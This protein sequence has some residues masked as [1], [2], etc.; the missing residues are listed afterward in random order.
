MKQ[1]KG[2]LAAALSLVLTLSAAA[3]T[4]DNTKYNDYYSIDTSS[5]TS[6][7]LYGNGMKIDPVVKN[8]GEVVNAKYSVKVTLDG[9]D[10]TEKVYNAE[11]KMFA[12]GE[13]KDAI[14]LYTFTITIVDDKGGEIKDENGKPF[15]A[16]FTV[17]YCTMNF[18]PKAS[19]GKGVTVDNTDP[20]SPVITFDST[21]TG[22]GE[23]DSGQYRATGVTF[24]GDYE[25]TYKVKIDGVGGGSPK[26]LYFGVDRTDEN[27]R[28]DNIALNVEDGTLSSWFFADNGTAGGS[29][30]TSTGWI[31]TNKSVSGYQ[32]LADGQEHEIG[33]TRVIS[34]SESKH[35]HYVVTWDGKYFTSLN[36]KGNYTDVLGG[37]WV[38]SMNVQ[39]S[40][41]I[42]SYRQLQEDKTSP[43]VVLAYEDQ[44]V[45]STIDLMK[46]LV[47]QDEI[48]NAYSAVQWKVTNPAGEDVTP[49]DGK[50]LLPDS[51]VY[52]V[53]VQVADLKG[54]VSEKVSA[55][56]NVYSDFNIVG[57][58]FDSFHQ[59]GKEISLKASF[60]S[61]DAE[62]IDGATLKI[63]KNGVDTNT[64]IKGN[65]KDGFKFTMTDTGVY[66]AKMTATSAGKQIE[67]SVEFT[68]SGADAANIDVSR[69]TREARTNVAH[70]V[71]AD[72]ANAAEIRIFKGD[73]LTGATDVTAEVMETYTTTTLENNVTYTYFKPK[74]AGRYFVKATFGSGKTYAIRAAEINVR[75]DVIWVYDNEKLD[76]GN[77]QLDKIIYGDNTVIFKANG[78]T[79]YETSKLVYDNL[80]FTGDYTIEFKV[81][82]LNF[83]EKNKKI[84]F[85][86][87]TYETAGSPW[88][89]Y[90]VC[91]EGSPEGDFWGYCTNI[92]GFGWVEYQ[93]R[94]VWQAPVTDEFIPDNDPDYTGE[95]YQYAFREG[96]EYAQYCQGT[97]TYKIDVK[98]TGDKYN[99][100]F[101]IDGRPEATHRNLSA[102]NGTLGC[103][104]IWANT[105]S[106]ALTDISVREI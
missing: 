90:D 93:W 97:H 96:K 59:V 98:K 104:V 39:G 21:Y 34:S 73:T 6:E 5:V 58:G 17:D 38:E 24:K 95:G 27:K 56:I 49:G 68:V 33:F 42:K 94:S 85:T 50:L 81:T 1:L 40:V 53:E 36:I 99:V 86:L 65:A 77:G 22:E 8:L 74:M 13:N 70:I 55:N 2:M 102:Q 89:W 11:T 37:V 44:G 10:V 88:G 80:N 14:G 60:T 52:K 63:Y 66:A 54:N 103:A 30:W 4:D 106:G 72:S 64:E 84:H 62:M 26:R 31:S 101:Y 79:N 9:K 47:V 76:I 69:N 105:M 18:V 23:N 61:D 20:L 19:A 82:D 3:C 35:G 32:T 92:Y 29:D 67:K 45:G 100:Y 87:G 25:I 41:G 15:T 57:F 83:H 91:L 48:Y 28:D 78:S 46:G 75:D 71:Y 12:P 51:G 16:V 7:L 43:K